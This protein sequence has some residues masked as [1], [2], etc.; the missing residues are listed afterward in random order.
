M[1]YE[2]K[3]ALISLIKLGIYIVFINF[4]VTVELIHKLFYITKKKRIIMYIYSSFK[5]TLPY[6]FIQNDLENFIIKPGISVRPQ[7]GKF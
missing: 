4:S 2:I 3:K 1:D 6:I 5:G 7:P